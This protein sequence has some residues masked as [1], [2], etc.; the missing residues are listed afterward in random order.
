MEV[1]GTG[2]GAVGSEAE[3]AVPPPAQGPRTNLPPLPSRTVGALHGPV[4]ERR[5]R[6]FHELG[7][8]REGCGAPI[9]RV[10]WHRWLGRL[11]RR[12]WRRRRRAAGAPG[13][14]ARGGGGVG[15]VAE[16]TSHRTGDSL[17]GG[18]GRGGVVGYGGIWRVVW[19]KAGDSGESTQATAPS[20]QTAA[21]STQAAA[22]RMFGLQPLR[23]RVGGLGGRGLAHLL[24]GRGE[25]RCDRCQQS[26]EQAGQVVLQG[27]TPSTPSP[28]HWAQTDHGVVKSQRD[29]A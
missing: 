4:R 26:I 29:L 27:P 9:E 6:R 10:P 22:P 20:T 2:W 7:G 1:A 28:L 18:G 14:E 19:D 16:R 17:L 21:P 8:E 12:G 13:G 23:L 3:L 25:P 15:G 24:D 11:R 5:P